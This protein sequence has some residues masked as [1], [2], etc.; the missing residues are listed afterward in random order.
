MDRIRKETVNMERPDFSDIKDYD[1][2]C[3]YYWYRDELIKIC[4]N[5]GLEASGGKIELNGIIQAYFSGKRV[6]P[7]MTDPRFNGIGL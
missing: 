7:N 6:M 5:L 1:E 4:K 2:F 3:K